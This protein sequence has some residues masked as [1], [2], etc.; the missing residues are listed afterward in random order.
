M[1]YFVNQKMNIPDK[2]KGVIAN[3]D[4]PDFYEKV[5]RYLSKNPT[6]LRLTCELFL[7]WIGLNS[8]KNTHLPSR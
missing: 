3:R 6:V 2:Y 4:D 8:Q 5:D 7:Y 1:F